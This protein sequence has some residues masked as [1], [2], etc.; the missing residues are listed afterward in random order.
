MKLVE[1]R[2][3]DTNGESRASTVLPEGETFQP[4]P[5]LRNKI[6]SKGWKIVFREVSDV[7]LPGYVDWRPVAYTLH[8]A[9]ARSIALTKRKPAKYLQEAM[10]LFAT[11]VMEENLVVEIPDGEP[12]GEP[13]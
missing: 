12:D 6:N 5:W 7:E 4:P 2:V 3:V 11:S 10:D 1:Y 8:A 13:G 9:L